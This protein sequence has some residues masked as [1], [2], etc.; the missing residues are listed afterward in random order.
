M[1]KIITYILSG[2]VVL[3]SSFACTTNFDET[4]SN[5]NSIDF[6][7]LKAKNYFEPIIYD[8]AKTWNNY[9]WY[10]CDQLMQYEAFTGTTREEHRYKIGEQDWNAWYTNFLS[11]W[12]VNA[13][14]MQKASQDENLVIIEAIAMTFKAYY[15]ANITDMFGDIPFSEA[16]K[17]RD[18]LLTP[19][20][21]TQKE[22]YLQ[23]FDLLEG[24]N[25]KY[26]SG[27]SFPLSMV[28]SDG[29]FNGDLTAWQ[30]F[31]NSLYLRCLMRV[32]GRTEM[33]AGTKI[34]EIYDNPAKY[35]I[36]AS[37]ADNASVKFTSTAPYQ[38][39]FAGANTTE[40][41]FNSE[42]RLAKQFIDMTVLTDDDDASKQFLDPRL[43]I[44]AAPDG[45]RPW[46]G[47]ISGGDR[48]DEAFV[49]S[50]KNASKLKYSVLCRADMPYTLIDY[51][52]VQFIFAESAL[53]GF[54]PGGKA[55][56]KTFYE[57]AVT[58]S[59]QRWNEE[60]PYANLSSE[61]VITDEKIQKY[62]NHSAVV[63][64]SSS[65][66]AELLKRIGDQK[67]LA[68]FWCGIEAWHEYRRTGYPELEI[69]SGAV[70]NDKI[71]P[72]RFAYLQ[73]SIGSNPVNAKVAIDRMK[74]VND[75]K[76]PL[77]WS[78]Q[79]ISTNYYND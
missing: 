35:P 58:A 32:S 8:G 77:W 68:L 72:T 14:A 73:N 17:G 41:N 33:N 15:M 50:T 1:K 18:G 62:L 54:I 57:S 45:N 28:S 53:K 26:A 11:R 30:K 3:I 10:W 65:D 66:D 31:N 22:V 67:Y 4:N 56:A 59:I 16:F 23:L 25:E 20:Y 12:A 24:A 44:W 70:Y 49:E 7:D 29:M 55:L 76:Q 51:A 43:N 19:K 9:T 64:N 2:I 74:G 60:A 78:K 38:N 21:D 69:G 5:P 37:N 40:Q 52:E 46:K 71:L 13:D 6:G 39:Y 36:I 42:R 27:E 75:M 63:F 48:L 79:A 61:D 47:V 34:K